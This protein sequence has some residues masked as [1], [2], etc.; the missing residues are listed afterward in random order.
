MARGC[1]TGRALQGRLDGSVR[2]CVV[3]TPMNQ[4]DHRAPDEI[5][6]EHLQKMRSNG[7][8]AKAAKMGVRARRRMSRAMHAAKAAK[9]TSTKVL[10]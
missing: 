7:G 9:K 6:A 3:C 8:K 10:V 2:P 1:R 4:P 5:I